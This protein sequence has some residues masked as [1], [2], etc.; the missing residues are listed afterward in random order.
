MFQ[1]LRQLRSDVNYYLLNIHIKGAE[2]K[3]L[4]SI[5]IGRNKNFISAGIYAWVNAVLSVFVM[6]DTYMF[7]MN[8]A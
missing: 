7:L 3:G 8:L 1:K 4:F 5:K 2:Y 6:I